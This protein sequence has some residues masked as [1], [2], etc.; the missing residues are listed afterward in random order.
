MFY[1]RDFKVVLKRLFLFNL[2]MF[3][4]FVA[5]NNSAIG[6]T[7]S[8]VCAYEHILNKLD[9]ESVNVFFSVLIVSSHLDFHIF[10]FVS[11]ISFN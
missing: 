9:H 4:D 10:S 3:Y 1:F 5:W 2:N 8:I 11:H 7:Y 6:A